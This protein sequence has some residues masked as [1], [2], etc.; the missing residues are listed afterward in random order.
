MV[1]PA[2]ETTWYLRI[3]HV[4]RAVM[5]ELASQSLAFYESEPSPETKADRSLVSEADRAIEL[6]ARERLAA[7]DPELAASSG[8]YGEEFGFLSRLG[9]PLPGSESQDPG[10][11]PQGCWV[12]DPIDGTTAFLAK[13]PT[14]SVLL[15]YL[16]RGEPVVGIVCFPALGEIYC[17]ARGSGAVFGRLEGGV[18][19]GERPSQ[20]CSVRAGRAL[21]EALV[22]YSSP[23]Q[24]RYRGLEG[25]WSRLGNSVADFRTFS[26]AFG[27]SRVLTGKIDAMID[28]IA[29]PYDLAAIQVLALETPGAFVGSFTCRT[30]ASPFVS[31]GM[32][33]AGS[34]SL[35]ADMA[36]VFDASLDAAAFGDAPLD[37]HAEGFRSTFQLAVLRA[38]R[39]LAPAPDFGLVHDVGCQVLGYDE[40]AW[41]Q[42]PSGGPLTLQNRSLSEVFVSRSF[43]FSKIKSPAEVDLGPLGHETKVVT[44]R[45]LLETCSRALQATNSRGSN[46]ARGLPAAG[47]RGSLLVSVWPQFSREGW[48]GGPDD[49]QALWEALQTAA[50]HVLAHAPLVTD[51]SVQWVLTRRTV[52][53]LGVRGDDVLRCDLA[54][55]MRPT[56]VAADLG[57]CLRV[58]VKPPAFSG[59]LLSAPSLSLRLEPLLRAAL[60]ELIELCD[61]GRG[62]ES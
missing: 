27:Y 60:L 48:S 54:W 12:L 10:R 34:P 14:W 37:S 15:A 29:T 5:L 46:T 26:D 52:R 16:H 24:F 19:R 51:R 4:G 6:L 20:Q 32:T 62:L 25:F 22:S 42:G 2:L 28:V 7:M 57:P 61:R 44:A 21:H 18:A 50:T 13:V 47:L 58:P 40:A 33:V 45:S 53:V 55:E 43:D 59:S 41:V 56:T 35:A 38:A 11:E 31:G 39:H 36:E 49:G 9:E 8:F 17:A 1:S 30:V 23:S 3:E